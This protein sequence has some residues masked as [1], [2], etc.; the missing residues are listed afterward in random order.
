MAKTIGTNDLIEVWASAGTATEPSLSKVTGGWQFEE[1]PPFETMNWVH[2]HLGAQINYLMRAG[3]PAWNLATTYATGDAV[4]HNGALWLSLTVNTNSEP[5]GA[6]SDWEKVP[7]ASDLA[8][9]ATT[10]DPADLVGVT[11]A[12]LALLDDA[13]AQDQRTTLGL[14]LA[15]TTQ[16]FN[17]AGDFA[18][19]F[20]GSISN[21]GTTAA[22]VS[23]RLTVGAGEIG[24]YVWAF[25]TA[26]SAGFGE[27]VAGSSLRPTS[28]AYKHVNPSGDT[29]AAT[30]PSGAA[31]TGTWRCM[32]VFTTVV[33]VN[34][35]FYGS[36]LW[37][38]IA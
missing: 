21:R 1:Q 34:P 30:L 13:T 29:G 36:T 2:N 33:G 35:D 18:T 32:G 9:V 38:R 15:A 27:T 3:V 19:V 26:G 28:A 17:E 6:S 37:Q 10:G 16:V 31:L 4:S 23:D 5:E 24:S 12:G 11:A 20:P 7:F 25:S 22:Y 14:T 8:T